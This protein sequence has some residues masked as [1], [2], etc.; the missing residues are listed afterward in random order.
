MS[1][2]EN[3]STE[4]VETSTSDSAYDYTHLQMV[5]A[6]G[7]NVGDPKENGPKLSQTCSKR[8]ALNADELEIWSNISHLVKF[9]VTGA[10]VS[11][12]KPRMRQQLQLIRNRR[13]CK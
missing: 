7:L 11:A 12:E 6:A 9:L 2:T 5:P 3:Q 1:E 4:A 8:G 13:N 10:N